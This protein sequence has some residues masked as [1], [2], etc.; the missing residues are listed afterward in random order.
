MNDSR[1]DLD[2]ALSDLSVAIG[3][4]Q[5]FVAGSRE[6]DQPSRS[7]AW[8]TSPR[9]WS[10]TAWLLENI[11]HIAPN[12][13]ANYQNIYYPTLRRRDAERSRSPTSRI[14]S[15]SSA[16]LIG[17]RREHHRARNGETVRAVPRARAA[18]AQLQQPAVPDQPVPEAVAP[19]PQDIIYT[20]PKLAPEVPGRATRPSRCRG[21]GLHRHPATS[22][23]PGLGSATGTAGLYWPG[24]VP[25]DPVAGVVPAAHR[26]RAAHRA[27]RA[28]RRTWTACCFR[29]TPAPAAPPASP[30]HAAASRRDAAIMIAPRTRGRRALT[31][32]V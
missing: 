18:T 24:E 5:R 30:G 4:V 1:S 21:V 13:V 16:A 27:A 12:A 29:P 7:A 23:R 2:A 22:R 10:T 14:R 32:V 19:N 9:S 8:P 11:L 17:A 28:V 6:P 26:S 3:E 15:I 31:G 20:D 25:A